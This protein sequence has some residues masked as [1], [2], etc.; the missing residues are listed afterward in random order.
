M[1][2]MPAEPS[3]VY[4]GT[5]HKLGDDL[6]HDGQMMAFDYVIRRITDP[7]ELVPHLLEAVR[8]GFHEEVKAGDIV[9]AGKRF[10]KGKAHVQAYLAMKA[11]G[12][13][14]A[15]ESMPYNTYRALIGIGFTFM[16][17]CT[18]ILDLVEQGDEIEIDFATGAFVNHTRG[19]ERSFKP[20]PAAALE[21]IRLGGTRGVLEQWWAKEQAKAETGS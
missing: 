12:L 17:G 8:P 6:E 3:W 11:L 7:A 19:L 15:C 18:G 21:I 20:L 14:V 16:T 9:V 13:A 5:C 10:G 4:R 2:T 1:G